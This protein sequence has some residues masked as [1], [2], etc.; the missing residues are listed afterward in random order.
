MINIIRAHQ[1]FELVHLEKYAKIKGPCTVRVKNNSRLDF[2]R[3]YD[4]DGHPRWILNLKAV[5]VKNLE[6]IEKMAR[7][8]EL[9]TYK[10]V[11]YY[12]MS[13]SIWE[14]QVESA[15]EM[16]VKGEELVAT[17]DY[18]DNILRCTYI[19]LVKRELPDLYSPMQD[20][21]Q[22]VKDL[23]NIIKNK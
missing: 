6:Y 20:I 9:L 15:N 10:E 11:S 4:G 3:I 8:R 17:F 7:A 5:W 1:K 14:E 18:V 12:L 2:N 22:E 23:E 13:G 21:A 16:P 19:T